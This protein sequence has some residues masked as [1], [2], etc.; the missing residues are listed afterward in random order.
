MKPA[1]ERCAAGT[2]R[3]AARSIARVYD[4]RLALAGLTT[5]QFSVLRAL[6]RH[7]SPV[8]LS[9]LADDMALERTSLY[10]ALEPMRREKLIVFSPG[11]GRAKEV[12]LTRGGIRRITQAMPHWTRAQE[13]FVTRYGRSEWSRLA[14]QLVEIVDVARTMPL[15][16]RSLRRRAMSAVLE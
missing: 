11:V 6:E 14:R 16:E 4:S 10:R 9:E 8:P 12:T 13:A 1:T 3:R 15:D 7:G 5:T 2:L